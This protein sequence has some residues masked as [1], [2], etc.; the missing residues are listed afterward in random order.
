[1]TAM[2]AAALGIKITTGGATPAKA[3]GVAEGGS[4]VF[5]GTFH[6]A[7][8]EIGKLETDAENAVVGLLNGQGVEVHDAMIATQRSDLA[9]QL[10]LQVRNK[11]VSA[12]QQMM[13]MQF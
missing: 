2:D 11:A 5:G 3:L 6:A 1:M 4:D 12:Y 8:Q 10:A 7:A 9:F 13:Q